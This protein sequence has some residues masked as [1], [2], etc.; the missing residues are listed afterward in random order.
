M[1]AST[2]NS[3]ESQMDVR[4]SRFFAIMIILLSH[5]P[6]IFAVEQILSLRRDF[7]RDLNFIIPSLA[8]MVGLLIILLGLSQPNRWYL[9]LD[10]D[11]KMLMVSY[12]IGSRARK[13]PYGSIFLHSG[14]FHIEKD[15]LSNR[16]GFL[17]FICN[18]ND[19]KVLVSTLEEFSAGT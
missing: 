7:F 4:F 18:S 11:T 5:A 12:G 19:L 13:Y 10:R 3:S 6:L 8:L 16:V 15:G 2:R 1:K 17:R 9:R 14:K